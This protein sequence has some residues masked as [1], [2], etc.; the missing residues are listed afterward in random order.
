MAIH[1]HPTPNKVYDYV[2]IGSGISG[3]ICGA[4]L[5][6]KGYLVAI[7][8]KNHQIGGSLQ[9]F[10]R[11]RKI[12]DTGV[13]YIGGLGH[14]QALNKLFRFLGIE[15]DLEYNRLDNDC[16]DRI[17]FRQ[18]NFEWDMP[19]G[20]KN[21]EMRLKEQFP[22]EKGGIEAF[23]AKIKSLV[24]KFGPY[25][26]ERPIPGTLSLDDLSEGAFH[27]LGKFFK[28]ELLIGLLG[29]SSIL[30]GGQAD[31]T[32]FYVYSLILN[33]YVEGAYRMIKGGS[34]IA[35]L[36]SMKIHRQGGDIFKYSEVERIETDDKIINVLCHEGK[37]YQARQIIGAIHPSVFLKMLPDRG[38]RS[39]Y[40]YRIENLSNFP[41]LLSVHYT[42]KPDQLPYFN[43]N[44][45]L[46]ESPEDAWKIR[47]D[48]DENWPYNC[49]ISTG[50]ERSSQQ[51]CNTI[52]VLAYCDYSK[53][54]PWTETYNTIAHPSFR[55]TDYVTQKEL[56]IEKITCRLES[57][58]PHFREM[59][60]DAYCSTPLTYRDYLSAP[61]GTPYGVKK[62]FNN[63]LYS[64]VAPKMTI[65]NVYLTG[66]STDLHGVYG[67]S[68]SALLTLS[69]L[70]V[71]KDIFDEINHFLKLEDK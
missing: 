31:S 62:N 34:Q 42:L 57:I 2:I 14:H 71:G 16:F 46:L 13:H 17:V 33:S 67:A 25:H 15:K 60:I 35:K 28:D 5:T 51:W 10:S 4:Y 41:S 9:V 68:V 43:H 65:P 38:L 18:N 63:I 66:Q 30:Y 58:F 19:Q 32:P 47:S 3:L 21:F 48:P 54:S 55:G 44:I 26:L 20:W 29:G 39:S 53:F 11:D 52:N 69:E 7:L 45:Y 64:F 49:M 27:A 40:R 37:S 56:L 70:E 22:A 6:G 1:R 8:E 23:C 61:E 24:A 12:L 59:I 36:L 50:C